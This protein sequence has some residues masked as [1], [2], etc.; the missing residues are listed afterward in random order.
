MILGVEPLQAGCGK[1]LVWPRCAGKSA[2]DTLSWSRGKVPT[3]KGPILVDWHQSA[4]GFR[5]TVE[6]PSTTSAL[7]RLP[8]DWGDRV[9]VDTKPVTGR[10]HGA[11]VEIDLPTPGRHSVAVSQ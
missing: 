4:A 8:S 7:V 10:R 2:A 6:L 9:L 5:M 1:T 11:F 3:P